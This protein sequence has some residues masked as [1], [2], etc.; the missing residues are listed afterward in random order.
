MTEKEENERLRAEIKEI[1]HK[2]ELVIEL[3][4]EEGKL[5]DLPKG[6][7]TLELWAR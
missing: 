6:S 1:R 4:R 5:R 3:L 7:S 2:F